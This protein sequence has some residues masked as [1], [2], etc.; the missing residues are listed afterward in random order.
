MYVICT[1]YNNGSRT[2]IVVSGPNDFARNKLHDFTVERV[3]AFVCNHVSLTSGI[4][5]GHQAEL[6]HAYTTE[7]PK[8]S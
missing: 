8:L 2:E 4:C 5:P 6:L 3:A 7:Q 1:L